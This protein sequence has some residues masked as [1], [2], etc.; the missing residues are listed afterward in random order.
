LK[1]IV[2]FLANVDAGEAEYRKKAVE[3]KVQAVATQDRKPL[4]EYLAG[5]IDTCAQIDL[6]L[7][8]SFV[9]PTTASSSSAAAEPSIS[10]ERMQ[11]Q[12][13]RH[14]ARLEQ[15]LQAPMQRFVYSFL[16]SPAKY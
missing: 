9:A 15:A 10:L 13:E 7:A 5:E 4:R 12:R 1:D 16:C 3:A 8:A 2:I 6:Q 11:E 14:A